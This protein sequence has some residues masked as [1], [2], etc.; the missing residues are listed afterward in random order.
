MYGV[1]C[2][3]P[4]GEMPPAFHHIWPHVIL[5]NTIG[6]YCACVHADNSQESI[7]L[8]DMKVVSGYAFLRTYYV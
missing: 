6:A 8:P 4:I 2:T 5:F 7:L 3:N 1:P